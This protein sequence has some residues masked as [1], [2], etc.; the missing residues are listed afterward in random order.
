MLTSRIINLLFFLGCL[1]VG[2][3]FPQDNISNAVPFAE[4]PSETGD[5]LLRANNYYG[6]QQHREA[7]KSYEQLLKNGNAD[8]THIF[9]RLALSHAA[10]DNAEES[11][12]YTEEYL[13]REF[14][15][16]FLVSDGM[17]NIKDTEP[18]KI[19][20]HRYYPSF[21][22]WSFLY[23]YVAF[24]GFYIVIVINLNKR[25]D[26]VARLLIGTFVLIHSIYILHICLFMTNF[27]LAFPHTHFMSGPFSFLYGPL[28]YFYFNR[29]PDHTNLKG[30]IFF[31]FCQLC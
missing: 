16:T 11:A 18:Y 5:L 9:K 17:K 21:D 2:Q 3:V 29:T 4:Q 20:M 31:I 1:T 10:L 23:I 22:I 28:L 24:I 8:S 30:K 7:L 19:L 15:V 12:F 26:R 13:A 27:Y 6:L 14:D 25:I